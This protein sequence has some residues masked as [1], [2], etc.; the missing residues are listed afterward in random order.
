[1][2][3]LG[4]KGHVAPLPWE[5]C[6]GVKSMAALF[7]E[8]LAEGWAF[9]RWRGFGGYRE[10]ERGVGSALASTGCIEG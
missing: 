3:L 1:M 4:P 7:L 2:A 8:V 9:G 5:T 10:E 6:V